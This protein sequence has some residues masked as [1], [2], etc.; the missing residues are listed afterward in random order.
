MGHQPKLE[1]RM[2]QDTIEQLEERAARTLAKMRK[3][4]EGTT[5]FVQEANKARYEEILATK[6]TK[7]I[8]FAI[9]LGIVT[10]IITATIFFN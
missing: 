5:K 7:W 10:A 1:E 8:Q 2:I 3:A 6:K 9:V 4:N